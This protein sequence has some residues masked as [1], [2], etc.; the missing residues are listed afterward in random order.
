[1]V[2]SDLTYKLG[3]D[4]DPTL[5]TSFTTFD[6]INDVN[7]G[8]GRVQWDHAIG[9]NSTANGGGTSI[10]NGNDDEAGYEALVDANN[11]AQNS[12]KAHW[13][14]FP[15]DPTV[16]G[17][18]DVILIACDSNDDA[19]A[20]TS[21]QIIVGD[22]DDDGDLI[23]NSVDPCPESDLSPTVIIDGTD[24][25]VVNGDFD[26]NGCTLADLINDCASSAKNHGQYVSC[27]A[28]LTQGLVKDGTISKQDRKAILNAA[29]QSDLP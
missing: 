27:V 10:P 17:T 29:A 9:N 3:F 18:Y 1:M 23:P 13:V 16:E 7:P 11:V 24:T 6:P 26:S 2:L 19:I 4:S 15:F 14:I 25:G 20:A 12:W 8:N 21:I 22:P 28:K 5:G